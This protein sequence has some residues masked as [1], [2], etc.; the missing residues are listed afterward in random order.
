MVQKYGFSNF[1][2]ELLEIVN[3]LDQ[4]QQREQDYLNNYIKPL[5]FN[6]IIMLG[7]KVDTNIVEIYSTRKNF[8][9]EVQMAR[10]IMDM[11]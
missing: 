9:S 7:W 6:Y 1:N 2:Y 10:Y 4:L 5:D 11:A 3:D 8:V